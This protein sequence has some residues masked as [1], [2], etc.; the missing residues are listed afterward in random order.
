LGEIKKRIRAAQ[1]AALR[2]VNLELLTL[3]WDIGQMITDRQR[4]R[5]GDGRWLRSS[6][7]IS[8]QSF[9]ALAASLPLTFAESFPRATLLRATREQFRASGRMVIRRASQSANRLGKG[10]HVLVQGELSTR[11]YDRTI[12]VPTGT[13]KSIEHTIQQLV[14]EAQS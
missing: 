6:L 5:I 3:Y 8:G 11:E 7:K 1:Y 12:N 4:G 9:Q 14:V 13:G 10:T 2:A